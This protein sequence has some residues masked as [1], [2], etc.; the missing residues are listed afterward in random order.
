MQTKQDFLELIGAQVRDIRNRN[1][2][3]IEKLALQSGLSYS[4]IIRIER[5]KI[6]TGI[7]QLYIIAKTLD[8]D[9]CEFFKEF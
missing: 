5:G 6:N 9:I 2:L 8:V 3:S 7:H 1:G 4:Q